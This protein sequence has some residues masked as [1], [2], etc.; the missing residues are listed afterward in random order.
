MHNIY[1]RHHA[2]SA[3]GTR[4][5]HPVRQSV[6]SADFKERK[7][8]VSA[9]R[10]RWCLA[11]RLTVLAASGAWCQAVRVTLT[12]RHEGQVGGR[13]GSATGGWAANVTQAR[14]AAERCRARWAVC[15][16]PRRRLLG[17]A[18]RTRIGREASSSSFALP[19][20]VKLGPVGPVRPTLVK[21]RIC[22][23][24]ILP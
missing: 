18:A 10:W 23:F 1:G 6:V 21:D 9:R 20:T 24:K 8:V 2:S 17:R 3:V 15:F 22:S 13:Q 14:C 4:V 16:L 5:H 19:G 12:R 7:S 11:R